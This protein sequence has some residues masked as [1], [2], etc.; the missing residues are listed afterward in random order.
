MPPRRVQITFELEEY[1]RLRAIARQRGVS[2]SS[3]VRQAV[4]K[5]Y[6]ISRQ[7]RAQAL[8]EIYALD[9]PVGEWSGR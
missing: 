8:Q 9:L 3:L 2:I 5:R 6:P 4:R 1:E 7:A